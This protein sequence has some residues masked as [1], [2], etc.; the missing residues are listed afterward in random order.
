MCQS[1]SSVHWLDVFILYFS[2]VLSFLCLHIYFVFQMLSYHA[3][4]S[5]VEVDRLKVILEEASWENNIYMSVITNF[6]NVWMLM[7]LKVKFILCNAFWCSLRR[8]HWMIDR[9]VS[10]PSGG[11]DPPEHRVRHRWV[12]LQRLLFGQRRHDHRVTSDVS[13]ARCRSEV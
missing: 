4:C 10:S 12:S 5:K 11:E 3:T 8:L 6:L 9:S 13:G 1:W 7:W 2:L